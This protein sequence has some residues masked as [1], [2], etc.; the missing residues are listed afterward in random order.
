[1]VVGDILFTEWKKKKKKEDCGLL[2]AFSG[3]KR[4]TYARLYTGEGKKSV[5]M[6]ISKQTK[7]KYKNPYIT[8]WEKMKTVTKQ[9][10]LLDSSS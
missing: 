4:G 9:W 6:W 1:M 5:K 10:T 8:D 7:K 2:W 3:L